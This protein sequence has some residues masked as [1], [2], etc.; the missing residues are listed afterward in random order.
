[1]AFKNLPVQPPHSTDGKLRPKEEKGLTQD[2]TASERQ[3]LNE[4]L[5]LLLALLGSSA[6]SPLY[7]RGRRTGSIWRV[8]KTSALV[9]N[10][11]VETQRSESDSHHAC[12][13]RYHPSNIFVL[14]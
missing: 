5:E 13:P 14:F 10:S 6:M 2:H 1:M 4:N 11:E 7:P 9:S 8:R 3:S 12:G